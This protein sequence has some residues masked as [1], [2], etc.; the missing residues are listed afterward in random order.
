MRGWE[1]GNEGVDEKG[2]KIRRNRK[3]TERVDKRRKGLKN[4][5]LR[6]GERDKKD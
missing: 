5:I 6:E 1:I 3:K 4:E 2:T